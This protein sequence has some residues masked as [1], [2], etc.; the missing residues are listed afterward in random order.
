MKKLIV[1][2]VFCLCEAAF[3]LQAPYLY[4]ADS[5]ADTAIQLTWRNNST[6]YQVIIIL[7]K[8][9]AAGQ[10][11]VI[12][13]LPGSATSFL[14]IVKPPVQTTYYYAL[15]AYSQTENA[16][17]SNQDS[18]SITP[19][20][21]TNIFVSPQ[22]LALSYDTLPYTVHMQFYDSSTVET[23]YKVYKSTNFAAFGMI[24]DIVSSTPSQKGVISFTDS[25]VS[26]NTWYRYY[27]LSYNSQQNLSSSIDTFFTFDVGA[28]A[29]SIPRKCS[30][31]NKLGSFPIKYKGW[32][33]KSGDTI[34]LNE[35]G[36]PDSTTFS[37]INVSNPSAPIFAGTGKSPSA[38][39][40]KTSLSKGPY[41]FGNNGENTPPSYTDSLFYYKYSSGEIKELSHMIIPELPHPFQSFQD[42]ATFIPGFLSDTTFI[43]MGTINWGMLYGGGSLVM[44]TRYS[45]NQNTLSL[46]D[47]TALYSSEV[48]AG[49]MVFINKT[50]NGRYILYAAYPNID[51]SV[52]IVD[53]N[54][55]PKVKATIHFNGQIEFPVIVDNILVDAPALKN[56]NNVIVDTVK[57]LVFALSDSELE[58]YNCQIQVGILHGFFSTPMWR[59]TLRVSGGN[60]WP[61][62]LIF[63]PHHNQP[64]AVSIFD[65]SGR[66]I[67]R[68]EGI[69]GETVA[70]PHQNRAGV[71]IV[72]AVLDGSAVTAKVILDR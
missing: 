51:S 53:F 58:I 19:K 45:F 47:T 12:N 63:L 4:S 65:L 32:S 27:A 72:R 60:G 25:A 28:M 21:P 61:E 17:T 16:D 49:F 40:G 15:T 6:T 70:W 71:Y 35:T 55:S 29:R 67:A 69:R 8:T 36:A 50:Y 42:P 9:S 41:I 43:T 22:N 33:L 3:G 5:V 52:K 56:V 20:K 54:H 11:S 59:Q 39:L 14:D 68:M 64:C 66:R 18:A 2:S 48:M 7:R 30:L 13:T 10:Y 37:I 24:K 57:N 1:L 46:I 44:A 31:V 23:G 34:V 62:S 38:M 26:P